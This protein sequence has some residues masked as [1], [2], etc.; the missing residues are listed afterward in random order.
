M[1]RIFSR[2]NESLVAL[3]RSSSLRNSP[4]T[5]PRHENRLRSSSVRSNKSENI[6][7]SKN[8]KKNENEEVPEASFENACILFT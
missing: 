5:I 6:K 7:L 8:K 1:V 2:S 4:T 3:G